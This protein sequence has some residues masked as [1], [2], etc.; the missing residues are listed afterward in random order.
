[1]SKPTWSLKAFFKSQILADNNSAHHLVDRELI[2]KLSRLAQIQIPEKDI[3]SLTRELQEMLLFTEKIREKDVQQIQ[4]WLSVISDQPCL[5]VW[6][7]DDA[8]TELSGKELLRHLRTSCENDLLI[9]ASSHLSQIQ[10]IK[11]RSTH[12]D[13]LRN[14]ARFE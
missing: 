2:N 11:K 13:L 1:L 4:P 10:E 3:T 5:P 12:D 6:R 14:E 9:I 7:N 8:K